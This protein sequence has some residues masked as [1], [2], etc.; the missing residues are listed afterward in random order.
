MK[1]NSLVTTY[2]YMNAASM[3]MHQFNM[4]I[5]ICK[6]KFLTHSQHVESHGSVTSQS[7]GCL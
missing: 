5:K 3:L 7:S 6:Q 4:T 2:F 1:E